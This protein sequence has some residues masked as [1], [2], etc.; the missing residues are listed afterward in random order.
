M[1]V[2]RERTVAVIG[3]GLMGGSLAAVLTRRGYRVSGWDADPEVTAEAYRM[4]AIS[5]PPASFAATLAGCGYVFIATPVAMIAAVIRDCLQFTAPGTVFSDLG[6]I[7]GQVVAAVFAFLPSDY[8]FVPGHPM[9]GSERYGIGAA[10]PFLFENAAYI[11]VQ[12]SRTPAAVTAR[13]AALVRATGAY[14]INLA[15]AAEHDRIVGLLSHLPHLV[16][17]T[18]AETAGAAEAAHPG[19]LALAAGGFRDTTRIATGAPQLWTEIIR[20]NREQILAALADFTGQLQK[21]SQIVAADDCESLLAFLTQARE[22]RLQIPAKNK[23]FLSLLYE[24]VVTIEDRPGAIEA[25][26]QDLARAEL[27]IKDIEILRIREGDG[28]TLRLAFEND[29]AVEKAVALLTAC[30]FKAWRR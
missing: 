14:V 21:L 10:D 5:R 18:L 20:G 11:V 7:K 19:T 16:A 28:G 29:A 27:N 2:E 9:T 26:L 6:S 30:G 24:M 13:L 1:T 17:A 4:G 12:E 23:G 3:L 22:T 15:S 8:Y 25:V